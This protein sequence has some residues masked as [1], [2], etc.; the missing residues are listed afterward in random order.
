M[1]QRIAILVALVAVA[2][3]L[4]VWIVA[5]PAHKFVHS[6]GRTQNATS[7]QAAAENS[8]PRSAIATPSANHATLTAAELAQGFR[9]IASPDGETELLVHP[10]S[11]CW[12]ELPKPG[13]PSPTLKA[14][15]AIAADPGFVGAEACQS[16][17]REK[18]AS[19]VETS[20]FKASSSASSKSIMGSFQVGKNRLLTNH[21]DMQ[22]EMV[23]AADAAFYQRV[24][25]RTLER[26]FRFDIVTGSG[27]LAQ[28]YLFWQE[29]RLFQLHVSYYTQLERWINS[30]G[31]HDG[32]AWYTRE[33]IPKCVECHATYIQWIPGSSNRYD[34]STAILGVGCERCHGPGREHVAFHER[35]PLEKTARHIAHPGKMS[36]AAT[37]DVC[38]QCH[39]GSAEPLQAPFSFRP[40]DRLEDFWKVY[41]EEDRPQGGVHSS[42]QLQRLQLSA[43]FAGSQMT[44]VD[45]HD[46]HR[47]EHGNI[48]LYSERCIRCHE[49]AHCGRYAELGE[50]L[51]ENC[52]DCHMGM[53]YDDHIQ[54]ETPDAIHLP[55]LRDHNIRILPSARL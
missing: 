21:P 11:P 35:Y 42:N 38:A 8:S 16:C 3:I 46:P 48:K 29:D 32:T 5:S 36:R 30:P 25:F 45:C 26:D 49:P 19:F 54:L 51:R 15:A 39:M 1:P 9:V 33:T 12:L 4:T 40:G 34:R 44:C 28:T 7:S 55:A 41:S 10:N 31:Y 23:Q 22:F 24:K 53:G 20:H 14:T 18:F 2:V 47:N 13:I 37:N 43:C 50:Q 52:I 17:H 6:P 27:T